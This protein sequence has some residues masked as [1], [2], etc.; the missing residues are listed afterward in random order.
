MRD[1]PTRKHSR[2]NFTD[3]QELIIREFLDQCA[4]F[5]IALPQHVVAGLIDVLGYKVIAP[6]KL[7]RKDREIKTIFGDPDP[8]RLIEDEYGP[9]YEAL[10]KRMEDAAG[11]EDTTETSPGESPEG[12]AVGDVL[13]KDV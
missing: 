1:R 4:D 3:E 10:L 13:L 8:Y 11:S 9:D 12:D 2:S 7:V 5:D 6:G